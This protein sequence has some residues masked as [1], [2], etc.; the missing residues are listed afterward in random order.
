MEF[1][2]LENIGAF[3]L[4]NLLPPKAPFFCMFYLSRLD[5]GRA[6]FKVLP[7]PRPLNVKTLHQQKKKKEYKEKVLVRGTFFLRIFLEKL[8]AARDVIAYTECRIVMQLFKQ[9]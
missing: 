7:L 6:R 1:P 9:R 3:D 2:F 5:E 8:G 4:N